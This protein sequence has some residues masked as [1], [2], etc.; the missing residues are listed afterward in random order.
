MDL[1]INSELQNGKYRILRVLGQG[2]FGITYLAE[3]VFLGRKFA[4][5][6][7]FPKDYCGREGNTSH[8]TLG[9]VSN[10]E[11]VDKLKRRFLKEA[12]NLA[13][14]DHPGIIKIHD[15]FEE[16]FTAYYVM[17]FVEGD[18]LNDVIK[19]DGVLSIDKA[20]RYT[21]LIGDALAYIHDKNMTH[22]DIKPSN[23]MIRKS[24]ENPV[25]IDF[26]LSKQYD[27]KGAITSTLLQAVSHGYSPM[28]LY[29]PGSI[30][31]FSP[32]SD[33][34]SLG[35]TLFY[36]V[37]GEI[38]PSSSEIIEKG[39]NLPHSLDKQ[40]ADF[41]S[42]C[43]KI[44][45]TKRPATVDEALRL[46]PDIVKYGTTTPSGKNKIDETTQLATAS[47]DQIPRLKK[48]CADLLSK[49][50]EKETENANL[51]D[52][53]SKTE[54]QY[55]ELQSKGANGGKNADK[56]FFSSR[57]IFL[58]LF[59]LSLAG[60]AVSIPMCADKNSKLIVAEADL[61]DKNEEVESQK[62]ILNSVAGSQSVFVASA[63]VKNKGGN[64]GE[65]IFGNK[66]KFIHP[67]IKVYNLSNQKKTLGIKIFSPSGQVKG[68]VSKGGYS[69]TNELPANH[70]GWFEISGWGNNGNKNFSRGN[71]RIE[72]WEDGKC[73]YK[74]PFVIY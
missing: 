50:A 28:E 22:F 38:P 12:R 30:N 13:K 35:A 51:K 25:L 1:K 44:S 59:V 4:I 20:T 72:V 7:F 24:D 39:L 45:R 27:Q 14:L 60:L 36:L 53:L 18:N 54:A 17:E 58:G 66:T 21:K 15:I 56:K 33:I 26:G 42:R 37:L 62:N 70:S 73:L 63:Q 48:Q 57:N 10:K 74:Y 49:I 68:K 5:K 55:R 9:T 32:Q 71:Y 52:N 64:Y 19:R 43:M 69:F 65:K 6:E 11:T 46:L 31:E 8:V 40:I 2:G 16:N 3:H 34:Y 61:A 29:T 41:I 47:N 23:I 67:R